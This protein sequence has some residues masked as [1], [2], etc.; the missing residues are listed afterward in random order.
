MIAF[1]GRDCSLHFCVEELS[2]VAAEADQGWN[3]YR[4][5]SFLPRA[6]G[7]PVWAMILVGVAAVI[8]VVI[9][10]VAM[11]VVYR[12]ARRNTAAMTTGPLA[13]FFKN[14]NINNNP[15]KKFSG[16][17]AQ[18]RLGLRGDQQTHPYVAF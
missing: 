8:I 16:T 3:V 4:A 13:V 11:A 15:S 12:K 9:A 18:K 7:L 17:G 6:P 5:S 1:Q 14:N 10:L 2:V